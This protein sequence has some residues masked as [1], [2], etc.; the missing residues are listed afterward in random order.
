MW[1]TLLDELTSL[2]VSSQSIILSLESFPNIVHPLPSLKSHPLHSEVSLMP[3]I[4]L[5][6]FLSP[7]WLGHVSQR[8][9][10]WL[11]SHPSSVRWIFQAWFACQLSRASL[12]PAVWQLPCPCLRS[13]HTW[14]KSA[15][16]RLDLSPAAGS[17]CQD[18]C[19]PVAAYWACLTTT[20]GSEDHGNT[21]PWLKWH[22][23]ATDTSLRSLPQSFL[24]T[25]G[26]PHC[27]RGNKRRTQGCILCCDVPITVLG[28]KL[29][30]YPGR[31]R[32]FLQK[33]HGF[34]LPEAPCISRKT[35][36]QCG[37]SLMPLGGL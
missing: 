14:L 37:T 6:A 25:R 31:F 12:S 5:A 9:P 2:L 32:A 16:P 34:C 1:K 19:S 3:P 20:H 8:E 13:A 7:T 36:S 33:E 30:S 24:F 26:C 17:C 18:V 35:F 29:L 15:L 10:M 27:Y 4:S 23:S 22:W 11:H 21:W 28:M